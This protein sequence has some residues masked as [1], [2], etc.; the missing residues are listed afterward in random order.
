MITDASRH[1]W[2]SKKHGDSGGGEKYELL[3]FK[4][5]STF[6]LSIEKDNF[7]IISSVEILPEKKTI[8]QYR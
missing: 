4:H 2:S 7:I 1:C 8:T 5:L 6:F 3:L